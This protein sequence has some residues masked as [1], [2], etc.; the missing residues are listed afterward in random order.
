[1]FA[2]SFAFVEGLMR[3]GHDAQDI[4][5]PRWLLAAILPAGFAL[6]A[7]RFVQAGRRYFGGAS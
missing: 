5:L 1:M 4:P 7:L 6:L 3:L 2:G